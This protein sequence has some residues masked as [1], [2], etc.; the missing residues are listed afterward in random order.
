MHSLGWGGRERR[1][2]HLTTCYMPAAW[3]CAADRRSSYE[4]LWSLGTWKSR[5]MTMNCKERAR[6]YHW[7]HTGCARHQGVTHS[8]N[9]I[10]A[11]LC[12]AYKWYISFFGITH[13]SPYVRVIVSSASYMYAHYVNRAHG[14]GFIVVLFRQRRGRILACRVING[15]LPYE[16]ALVQ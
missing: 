10:R 6:I 1:R 13:I 7:C 2:R 3:G 15:S 12:E 16:A 8:Y 4:V 14:L 5:P 11:A 9:R